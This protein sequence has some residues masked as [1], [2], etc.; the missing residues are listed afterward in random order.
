MI[1]FE[2]KTHQQ[3]YTPG[4]ESPFDAA[5]RIYPTL[6]DEEK[7]V[8][9]TEYNDVYFSM[10]EDEISKFHEHLARE[11]AKRNPDIWQALPRAQIDGAGNYTFDKETSPL[12]RSALEKFG[13][14]SKSPTEEEINEGIK[15]AREIV[16]A[17]AATEY[18][19]QL[20]FFGESDF[21]KM[22]TGVRSKRLAFVGEMYVRPD[23]I[24]GS[25]GHSSWAGRG[26]MGRGEVTSY[27]P[28]IST[29]WSIN[30]IED[31]ATRESQLPA[32]DFLALDLILTNEG[33]IVFTENAHR[34]S[35][36]K[37]RDEP[38]R[39]SSIN[40]YDARKVIQP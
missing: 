16:E 34:V 10:N 14:N 24:S 13:F 39:F 37:L 33:P 5:M 26:D 25:A 9:T 12:V 20:P 29:G 4:P 8:G 28:G 18:L 11:A 19:G 15:K 32:M 27:K 30:N 7:L 2:T 17:G 36:A 21:K 22:T 23:Q 35:A 3:H 1:K 6:T 38:L 31:F 40:I